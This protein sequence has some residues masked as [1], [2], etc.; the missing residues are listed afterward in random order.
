M[1]INEA[2]FLQASPTNGGKTDPSAPKTRLNPE[3]EGYNQGNLALYG[4]RA[5]REMNHPTGS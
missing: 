4:G 2:F 1:A 5:L 3:N